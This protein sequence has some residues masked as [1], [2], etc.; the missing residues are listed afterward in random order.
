MQA[1]PPEPEPPREVQRRRP[2]AGRRPS[3][4]VGVSGGAN[5]TL[6]K[7]LYEG[8]GRPEWIA[9]ARSGPDVILRPASQPEKK[10]AGSYKVEHISQTGA[11]I[12][13][14]AFLTEHAIANGKY[15][16]TLKGTTL[17]FTPT[18]VG[19]ENDQGAA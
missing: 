19:V 18:Y 14:A 4:F 1:P 12:N 9:V 13:P 3:R 16:P 7:E 8:M 2:G 6:G 15:T 11:G 10:G 17:T 5:I